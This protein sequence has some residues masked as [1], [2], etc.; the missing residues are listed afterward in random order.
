MGPEREQCPSLRSP[1]GTRCL[2]DPQGAGV[3]EAINSSWGAGPDGVDARPLTT[4][5]ERTL[6][7][8]GG[9]FHVPGG[10]ELSGTDGPGE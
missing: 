6:A 4:N 8:P 2:D 3:I 5:P 10:L 7:G 9:P 1:R